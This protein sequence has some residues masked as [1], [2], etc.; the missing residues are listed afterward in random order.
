MNYLKTKSPI[1]KKHIET[2]IEKVRQAKTNNIDG[3]VLSNLLQLCYEFGLKKGELIRLSVRDISQGG[4]VKDF[5]AFGDDKI[6]FKT[7][8]KKMIQNHINYLL[9]EGYKLYPTNPLFPNRRGK[10]RYSAETLRNHLDKFFNEAS[11][12]ISL[13]KIRKAAVC[14]FYNRL[15]KTGESQQ[16]CLEST[17]DFA[18]LPHKSTLNLLTDQIQAT[19]KKANPV[20]GYLKEI[21]TLQR[22]LINS[23]NPIDRGDC[24]QIHRAIS[25]D[26]ELNTQEKKALKECLDKAVDEAINRPRVQNKSDSKPRYKSI[27]EVVKNFKP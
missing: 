13:E 5:L 11:V 27:S 20:S 7:N 19:G 3:V 25:S 8:Q 17:A 23:K 6:E 10:S 18:R 21:E 24:E 15:K 2:L 9:A 26:S 14:N 22:L 4:T 1:A 12:S 16:N